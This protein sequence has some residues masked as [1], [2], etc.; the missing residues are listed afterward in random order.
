L[1][2]DDFGAELS[3]RQIEVQDLSPI[4]FIFFGPVAVDQAIQGK[5]P[6]QGAGFVEGHQLGLEDSQRGLQG[7]FAIQGGTFDLAVFKKIQRAAVLF[8]AFA[9]F[10]GPVLRNDFAHGGLEAVLGIQHARL[11]GAVRIGHGVGN[12]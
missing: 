7:E 10:R 2:V 11:Q 6:V 1:Q 12:A 8:L 3:H 5:Q 9:Q 4:A